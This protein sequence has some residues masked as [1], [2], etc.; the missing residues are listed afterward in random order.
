[1]K[2]AHYRVLWRAGAKYRGHEEE[3]QALREHGR[4]GFEFIKVIKGPVLVR[5]EAVL[6]VPRGP[7]EHGLRLFELHGVGSLR[8]RKTTG[9]WLVLARARG[10]GRKRAAAHADRPAESE[11][12][13]DI[14]RPR[15]LPDRITRSLHPVGCSLER[16]FPL[17]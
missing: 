16:F 7:E 3:R 15:S 5:H 8:R 6:W 4:L 9:G 10:A 1:M 14:I 17:A 12:A 13:A 11:G 2:C